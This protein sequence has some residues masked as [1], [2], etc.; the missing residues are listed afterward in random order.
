MITAVQIFTASQ[1]LQRPQTALAKPSSRENSTPVAGQKSRANT[2]SASSSHA[3]SVAA[4]KTSEVPI[5]LLL[6]S[7]NVS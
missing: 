2:V 3:S 7:D 1:K 4:S 6:I 5:A